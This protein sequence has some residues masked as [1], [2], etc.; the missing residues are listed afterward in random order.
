M[1]IRKL[2]KHLKENSYRSQ[3]DMNA[4]TRSLQFKVSL[5]SSR[6][7]QWNFTS[8]IISTISDFVVSPI[9]VLHLSR[10]VRLGF[11]TD[12]NNRW[13]HD[14]R[15]FCLLV[16]PLT[17]LFSNGPHF[18]T[19]TS[20][21]LPPHRSPPPRSPP[22]NSRNILPIPPVLP[23]LSDG[24]RCLPHPANN[25]R[26]RV[27]LSLRKGL[28]IRSSSHL[29]YSFNLKSHCFVSIVQS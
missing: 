21:L 24:R 18:I 11:Q 9:F 16:P 14:L 10:L 8:W 12:P 26:T 15:K 6:T 29:R 17:H 28:A 27:S 13:P 23:S 19:T 5:D 4:C 7:S 25:W 20:Y 22:H 3:I 1:T 2:F